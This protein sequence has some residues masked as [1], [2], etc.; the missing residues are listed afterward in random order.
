[1]AR[2]SVKRAKH[3]ISAQSK[4]QASP[5]RSYHSKQFSPT[6]IQV[7]FISN[8]AVNNDPVICF[9]QIFTTSS[10]RRFL[11]PFIFS[12]ILSS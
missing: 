12:S 1:M 3:L 11:E 8:T 4:P 2:G 7:H 6:T 5:P 10:L 9:F